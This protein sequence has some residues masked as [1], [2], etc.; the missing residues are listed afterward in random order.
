MTMTAGCNGWLTS[1]HHLLLL[2]DNLVWH[3]NLS[4]FLLSCGRRRE[5]LDMLD[6]QV[7]PRLSAEEDKVRTRPPKHATCKLSSSFLCTHVFMS[8]TTCFHV[9]D[10]AL[11]L[12][13]WFYVLC[14]AP[15]RRGE[16]IDH[17]RGYLNAGA[18]SHG[19]YPTP[20]TAA[21]PSLPLPLSCVVCVVCLWI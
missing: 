9:K 15:E 11:G 19:W 18:R 1:L 12:E 17:L 5:G 3:A 8:A 13:A 21:S 2:P 10:S 4:G 16:A 7:I 14:Y 6:E 20:P